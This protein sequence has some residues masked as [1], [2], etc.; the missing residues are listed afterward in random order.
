VTSDSPMCPGVDSDSKNEYQDNP[1]GKG[2]RCVRLT[3]YHLHVPIAKKFGAFTSWNPVGLF[4]PV[5]RQLLIF[6][7]SLYTECVSESGDFA[8]L[9]FLVQQHGADTA[10]AI[11][12]PTLKRLKAIEPWIG[13][14]SSFVVKEFS[15]N[16]SSFVIAQREF[17][18]EFGIHRNRDVPSAHAIKTWF[19]NFEAIGSTLKK[20]GGSVKTVRTTENIAV[21]IEAIERSSHRSASCHSVSLGQCS[22]VY[23]LFLHYHLSSLV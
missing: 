22:R 12:L 16:G 11:L 5:M 13:A 19:R 20:K 2:G 3:T 9:F 4:R 21:V 1:G 15:K 17:R 23:L 7:R 18:I 10:I 6:I 14:Q 8:T